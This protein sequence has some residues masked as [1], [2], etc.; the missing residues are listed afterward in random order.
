MNANSTWNNGR[1]LDRHLEAALDRPVR[2]ENDA[3]C[4][5]ISEATDGAGQGARVVWG[6]I[7]GTGAGSGL[8]V[9]GRVLGGRNRIAGEWGHNPLPGARED[10]RPG[11]ACYCGR[12]GCVETF[13]SGTGFEHDHAVRTGRTLS[14]PEIVAALRAGDPEA[15]VTLARYRERLARALAAVVNILDPDVIVLGGGMSNVDEIYPG[16]AEEVRPHVFADGF[17]TPIRK[18]RHGDSSGVRGAAW[19]WNEGGPR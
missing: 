5:A 4:F 19:L 7:I 1:P 8:V 13:V 18:H 16:L 6:V 12:V 17:T 11:P 10:E 15:A 9:D 2:I 14:G 3:N